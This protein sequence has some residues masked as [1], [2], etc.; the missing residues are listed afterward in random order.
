MLRAATVE[1][2]QAVVHVLLE[3]RRNFLP[4]AQSPHPDLE[5]LRWVERDLI[6]TGGVT[7]AVKDGK[8]IAVL[9]ISEDESA[10]WIV[11]RPK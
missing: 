3:S 1:D 4:Y 9:A 5:T 10:A 6:P 8:I 7:V 2:T 11:N